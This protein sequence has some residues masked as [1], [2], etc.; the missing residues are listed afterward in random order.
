MNYFQAHKLL[1]ETR[2]GH[3]HTEADITTALS[4]TGDIDPDLLGN[5]VSWWR[6]SP[7][8]RETGLSV[9]TVCRTGSG[10]SGVSIND[11]RAN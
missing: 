10:F 6:S 4:L 3:N 2:N 11:Y 1:D 5:G 8:R 7:K 9:A